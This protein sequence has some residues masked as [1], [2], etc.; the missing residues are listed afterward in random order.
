MGDLVLLGP[1]GSGKG[2][3]AERIAS[4]KGWIH[5]STGDLFRDHLRRQTALGT[6][7]RGY[8]DR[9]ELV[10]DSVTV[11][12]VREDLRDL[13]AA[14]RVIFDGFPRTVPQAEALDRLFTELGRRLAGVV[15][16]EVPRD[17]L[18]TRIAKRATCAN[19]QAVYSLTTNPPRRAG[20][21]DRC[22]GPVT[23]RSD[24]TPEVVERRLLVYEAETEPLVDYYRKRGQL[25]AIDGRGAL[26]EVSGRIAH[27]FA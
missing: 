1:P 26:D 13:P 15:L 27:A 9:G 14:T 7:A 4:Q 17:E 16:M 18:V 10:P 2:T 6:L 19:C 20:V 25:R 23:Q 5:L 8:I 24:E 12:M 21:C 22:G 3:Q 11:G